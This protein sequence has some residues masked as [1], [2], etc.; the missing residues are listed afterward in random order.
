MLCFFIPLARNRKQLIFVITLIGIVS[1][2]VRSHIVSFISVG[3]F[4]QH[5]GVVLFALFGRGQVQ[6]FTDHFG[7]NYIQFGVQKEGFGAVRGDC[8]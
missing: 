7:R 1:P 4:C 6:L 3:S 2:V 8:W 5:R